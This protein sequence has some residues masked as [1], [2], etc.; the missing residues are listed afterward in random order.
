MTAIVK[1]I[2]VD[3]EK[4]YTDDEICEP[5]NSKKFYLDVENNDIYMVFHEPFT[6]ETYLLNLDDIQELV[7]ED[8][9]D[10]EPC[11]RPIKHLHLIVKE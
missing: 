10:H 11:F 7:K 8:E 1:E 9:F 3:V 2:R 6:D 5:E 4:L